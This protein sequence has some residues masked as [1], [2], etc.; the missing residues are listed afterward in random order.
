MSRGIA[1]R[2]A[3]SISQ[4]SLPGH[5][6]VGFDAGVEKT[7]EGMTAADI[8][9]AWKARVAPKKLSMVQSGDFAKAAKAGQ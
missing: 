8:Q 2:L 5:T 1:R 4:R 9:A 6:V 3:H 7:I